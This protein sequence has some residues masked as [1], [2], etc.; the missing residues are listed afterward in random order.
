MINLGSS[1]D[2]QRSVTWKREGYKSY[3]QKQQ[4][5]TMQKK[6]KEKKN[7]LDLESV[8]AASLKYAATCVKK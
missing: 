6:K 7:V 5:K 1:R 4:Y 8:F 2:A 3:Y